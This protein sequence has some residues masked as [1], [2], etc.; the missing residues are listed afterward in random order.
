MGKRGR[1]LLL[2]MNDNMLKRNKRR[3][4][5]IFNFRDKHPRRKRGD[6]G[7][8]IPITEGSLVSHIVRKKINI[9]RNEKE[10]PTS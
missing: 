4:Q 8:S 5:S 3:V 9:P 7:R 1:G 2:F 6:G 10:I